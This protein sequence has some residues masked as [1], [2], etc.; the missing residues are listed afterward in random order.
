MIAVWYDQRRT[1][2]EKSPILLIV[3]QLGA[4]FTVAPVSLWRRSHFGAR[5]TLT[6]RLTFTPKPCL[7]LAPVSLW[8]PS[9]FGALPI[10]E[11]LFQGTAGTVRN[12]SNS[13][14]LSGDAV[15]G[16]PAMALTASVTVL[17]GDK[18]DKAMDAACRETSVTAPPLATG[19]GDGGCCC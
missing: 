5:L 14:L 8:R 2:C 13:K 4:R 9:Y 12:N 11:Q 1:E 3:P 16:S 10:F 19:G 18:D 17:T 6:P 7:T 15:S